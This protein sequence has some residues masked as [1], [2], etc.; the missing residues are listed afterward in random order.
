MRERRLHNIRKQSDIYRPGYLSSRWIN[1]QTLHAV[2]KEER[3]WGSKQGCRLLV[4]LTVFKWQ[5]FKLKNSKLLRLHRR[6]LC[7]LV[8]S[9]CRPL[10]SSCPSL[11]WRRPGSRGHAGRTCSPSLFWR[12]PER[13]SKCR[14]TRGSE[15][16]QRAFLI[17]ELTIS[18]HRECTLNTVQYT[19][20]V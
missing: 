18:L 17:C 8:F 16:T 13:G 12:P 19:V 6:C 15:R 4:R 10:S 20:N 3:T 1:T 11:G 14:R 5:V 9:S 7:C 2:S